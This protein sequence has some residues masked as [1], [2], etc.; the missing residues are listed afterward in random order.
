MAHDFRLPFNSPTVNL[1]IPPADYID[2]ISHMAEY[3]NAE[4][5]EVESEKEWPVALLGGK[6][7]IHLIHYPS[8]AAGSEAWHRREQRINSDRC[9]YVLVETDGCTYNDLKRFD[10]LPFKH[11]VALVH[12]SYPDIKCAFKING[13]EQIGA[14]TDS[15]CFHPLLPLRKYDQF[16]WKIGRASCRERV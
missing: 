8:V 4:M 12:K 15:Y 2:Y 9:Y 14:V 5:R 6:I 3:T 1:M 11:K 10:N 13:Y 16:N 7:H